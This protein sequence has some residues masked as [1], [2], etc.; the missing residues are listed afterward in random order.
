MAP[1]AGLLD[2]V[3]AGGAVVAPAGVTF[4]QYA[5]SVAVQ[6]DGYVLVAGTVNRPETGDDFAVLRYKP[7][8]TL[9]DT[10]GTG[11]M[12]AMDIGPGWNRVGTS[13]RA[14]GVAV[15]ADGRIVVAGSSNDRVAVA[16]LT[17]TGALDQSFNPE[18]FAAR[19]SAI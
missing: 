16:R 2:P 12:V 6:L 3:F 17:S 19:Q 5:E 1:A 11:G 13:D 15:Q 7:D 4:S 10:F 8:G 14:V 9:D 18:T